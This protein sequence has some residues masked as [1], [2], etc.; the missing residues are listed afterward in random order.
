M[1]WCRSVQSLVKSAFSGKIRQESSNYAQLRYMSRV[2]SRHTAPRHFWMKKER[3]RYPEELSS[4]NEAFLR[5]VV[6]DRYESPLRHHPPAAPLAYTPGVR[7][8]GLVARKIAVQPIW[9]S[10]GKYVNTTLLH[11]ADNHVVGYVP[12]EMLNQNEV[13]RRRW[14]EQYRPLAGLVV[15]AD[16]EDPTKFTKE[17]ANMFLEA[18]I[19]PTKKLTRFTISPEAALAPGTRLRATHFQVGDYVDVYAKTRERGFQGV[20]KRWGFAGQPATHG[21]TKTHRRPGGIGSGAQKSRVWPGQ[22]MPGHMGGQ[23]RNLR[24]LKILRINTKH[25]IIYVL[26]HAVPG[27]HNDYVLIHDTVLPLRRRKEPGTVITDEEAA[28]LPEDIFHPDV[29]QMAAPSIVF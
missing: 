1:N 28:Q 18:G 5:E 20:M 9:L 19:M 16:Q 27:D 22:K 12:P 3:A 24:G 25:D 11:V 29:H 7:R 4:E 6:S 15:G 10:N 8:C 26:G 13:V 21:A 23:Y 17:Y 14:K 2:K